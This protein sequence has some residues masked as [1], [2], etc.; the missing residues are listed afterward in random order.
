MH[1]KNLTCFAHTNDILSCH[2]DALLDLNHLMC[3]SL[4]TM[5]TS[6]WNPNERLSKWAKKEKGKACVCARTHIC[7]KGRRMVKGELK[8]ENS[9]Y[10]ISQSVQSDTILKLS[11]QAIFCGGGRA[12]TPFQCSRFHRIWNFHFRVPQTLSHGIV[13]RFLHNF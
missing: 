10:E 11:P 2:N 4:E 7:M 3:I 8:S 5:M 6:T 13:N 12:K 1:N 9:K